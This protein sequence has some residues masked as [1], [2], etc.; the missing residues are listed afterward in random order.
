MRRRPNSRVCEGYV[1][2]SCLKPHTACATLLQGQ[3]EV[4]LDGVIPWLCAQLLTPPRDS[5]PRLLT[6]GPLWDLKHLFSVMT[7][8]EAPCVSGSE[9]QRE[10]V[11]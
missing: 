1:Q 2:V 9:G 11:R 8:V 6:L 4:K 3:E 10:K 7:G 5:G